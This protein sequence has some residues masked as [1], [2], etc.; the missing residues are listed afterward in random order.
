MEIPKTVVIIKSEEASLIGARAKVVNFISDRDETDLRIVTD[1]GYEL[2]T[3]IEFV[4][5]ID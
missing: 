3:P 5:I 2:W 1:S 4:E